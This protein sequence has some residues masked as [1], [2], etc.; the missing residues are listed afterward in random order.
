MVRVGS[1]LEKNK[2]K[3]EHYNCHVGLVTNNT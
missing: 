2:I 3:S 1:Y